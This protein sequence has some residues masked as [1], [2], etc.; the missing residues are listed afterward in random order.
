ME[1]F[2]RKDISELEVTE[3]VSPSLY[4]KKIIDMYNNKNLR[5]FGRIDW[6]PL[7]QTDV[8]TFKSFF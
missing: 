6:L 5:E 8:Q 7:I 4:A 2:N 3:S 1:K